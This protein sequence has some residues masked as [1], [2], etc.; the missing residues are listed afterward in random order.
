MRET[1]LTCDEC[2]KEIARG[3]QVQAPFAATAQLI[4]KEGDG[5]MIVDL[6]T[7]I[8]SDG[9]GVVEVCSKPCLRALI[10]R[11][12]DERLV[13]KDTALLVAP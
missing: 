11:A 3:R 10:V 5:A 2:K 8:A 13:P 12:I 1:I 9:V 4:A 6:A 7:G